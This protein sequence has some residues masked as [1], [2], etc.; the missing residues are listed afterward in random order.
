MV[1]TDPRHLH[2]CKHSIIPD[3]HATRLYKQSLRLS[4]A[5]SLGCALTPLNS[6]FATRQKTPG[7]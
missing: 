5:A 6:D 3:V 1:S 2:S 7:G 4:H